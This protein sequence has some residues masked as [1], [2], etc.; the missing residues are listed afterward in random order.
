MGKLFEIGWPIVL[1]FLLVPAV[2]MA[3]GN[4]YCSLV[5]KLIDS[6]GAEDSSRQLITVTEMNG[7]TTSMENRAGGVSFCDLGI[8]PVTIRVSKSLYCRDITLSNV[9]MNFGETT[10]IKIMADNPLC[11]N[12]DLAPTP[13]CRV[14]LRFKDEEDKW[15]SGITLKPVPPAIDFRDV[16]PLHRANAFPQSDHAGRILVGIEQKA[17]LRATATRDGYMPQTIELP[18]TTE[19]YYTE[20]VMSMHKDSK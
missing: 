8:L 16:Y 4:D 19:T 13:W 5:V 9:G 20:R 1:S 2:G 15:I 17:E 3:Q 14:L 18:C 6:T 7:R 11:S 10:T 12:V